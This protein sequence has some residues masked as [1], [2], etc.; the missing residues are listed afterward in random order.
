[1]PSSA[2]SG[3]IDP[4][5]GGASGS[6]GA[7]ERGPFIQVAVGAPAYWHSAACGLTR[8]GA[9]ECWGLPGWRDL[10]G[11]PLEG[12]YS[13]FSSGDDQTCGLRRDGSITC[14]RADS[15]EVA[16]LPGSYQRVEVAGLACGLLASGAIH[17]SDVNGRYSGTPVEG[18]FTDVSLSFLGGTTA[19]HV[20]PHAC[21]VRQDRAL[22]CWNWVGIDPLL[23][24][25]VEAPQGQFSQVAVGQDHACALRTDRHVECWGRDRTGETT[26][27]EGEFSSIA[28]GPSHTCGLR[29]D[30]RVECWGG[31]LLLP[32]GTFVQISAGRGGDCALTTD[33]FAACWG[34][35]DPPP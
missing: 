19:N 23:V 22:V 25:A 24:E 15:Q 10:S 8:E 30:G 9:I 6:G 3:G 5:Q 16:E 4:S 2:G 27:L 13:Q 26:P 1:M 34:G 7:L 35:V 12:P 17:C 11:L 14:F 33:G 21:A 20:G 28:S 31:R 18:R 32:D 29:P